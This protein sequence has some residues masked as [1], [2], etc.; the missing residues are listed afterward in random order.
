MPLIIKIK[1]LSTLKMI[2]FNQIPEDNQPFKLLKSI[3]NE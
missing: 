2:Q 1:L 3:Y